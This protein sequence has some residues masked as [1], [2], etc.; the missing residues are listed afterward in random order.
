MSERIKKINTENTNSY[1][2]EDEINLRDL[3]LLLWH[4][5]WLIVGTTF[6][7]SVFAL[8]YALTQPN[9]YKSEALLAP[10]EQEQSLGGLQAQLGGLASLAGINLGGGASSNTKLAIEI[11]KSRQ[12]TSEFIQK[13]NILPDLMAAESWSFSENKVSYD[14]S[15]YNVL[16]DKW[17]RKVSAPRTSKPSMQEAYDFFRELLTINE[18]TETGMVTISI[19]H[20][21]PFISQQWVNW[22][23]EDI[24]LTMKT[25]DVSEARESTAFLISQIEKMKITDIRDVLYKMVEEQT[26]TIMFANVR[27]E[28]V[29]K[30]IDP[31][32]LP[33]EKSGPKRVLIC[34]LGAILGGLLSLLFVFM[35]NFKF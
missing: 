23:I 1:D 5:K 24:N 7:F 18:N 29:F 21:S 17:V 6:L 32:M 34:L 12:F 28:Y 19:E 16:E 26:K 11:L 10:I 22:L 15:Q 8:I 9:T 2:A 33:E 25:R 4:E 13:H 20:I 35:R 14:V 3:I 27:E 31:A 30:T